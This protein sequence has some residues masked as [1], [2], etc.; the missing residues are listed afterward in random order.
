M[1]RTVGHRTVGGLL[2]LVVL[3]T[4]AAC[5][6]NGGDAGPPKGQG[7]LRF[8]AVLAPPRPVDANTVVD[9]A[10]MV[11][12]LADGRLLRFDPWTPGAAWVERERDL[13]TAKSRLVSWNDRVWYLTNDRGRLELVSVALSDF[14]RSDTRAVSGAPDA[15]LGILA[16]RD[17][18]YV[19]GDEGGFRI[20]L[21]GGYTEFP[22]PPGRGVVSDWSNAQLAE[23]SDG[24]IVVVDGRRLRWIFEPD[25]LRWRPPPDEL[26]QREIRSMA[27]S[28]D[29]AYLY[30]GSP[31]EILRLVASNRLEPVSSRLGSGCDSAS[32]YPTDVG[33]VLVSCGTVTLVDGDGT[34][35]ALAP[36]GTTIVRGPRGRPLA[37][38]RQ[39]GDL[40]L[41]EF[42]K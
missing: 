22:G 25:L 5:S 16:A 24:S 19:F 9:N 23:L 1:H 29:G 17:A 30:A 20:D 13:P 32:L 41:L 3:T 6:G 2:A 7:P 21:D 12:A 4:I 11:L 39:P 28:D 27:A 40:Y 38:R 14:Q 15:K 26:G 36:E 34:H 37:V 31:N 42:T 8:A 18:V 10:D 35:S 33:L